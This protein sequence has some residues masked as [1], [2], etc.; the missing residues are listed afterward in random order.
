MSWG[1]VDSGRRGRDIDARV[2]VC[3]KPGVYGVAVALA[4]QA[5]GE[6]LA[7]SCGVHA[8]SSLVCRF[9]RLAPATAA[10]PSTSSVRAADPFVHS[11]PASERACCAPGKGRGHGGLVRTV[12]VHVDAESALAALEVFADLLGSLA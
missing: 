7:S 12:V 8:G 4:F 3:Q 9:W 10:P 6:L 1:G 2:F 11:L 5:L